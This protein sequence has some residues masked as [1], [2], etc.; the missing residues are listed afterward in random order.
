MGELQVFARF[1]EGTLVA[2]SCPAA[3][4]VAD[5]IEEVRQAGG[6][7]MAPR[8]RFLEVILE[9]SM[10]VADTGVTSEAVVE[11]VPTGCSRVSIA[12]GSG[13]SLALYQDGAKMLA[14]GGVGATAQRCNIP[15]LEEF[16]SGL[17]DLKVAQ[18]TSG[19][20]CAFALMEDQTV[21]AWGNNDYGQRNVPD[22]GGLKVVEIAAGGY[23]VIA[24]MEDLTVRAWGDNSLGQCRIPDFGGLNVIKI[25]GGAVHSMAL[26]EDHTVRAWG[27]ND[28]GQCTV[29]DLGDEKVLQIAAGG[30]HSMVLTENHVVRAWGYNDFGQ[31]NLTKFEG[32]KIEHIAAGGHHSIVLTDDNQV[33]ATG[34]VGGRK[35]ESPCTVPDFKGAKVVQI[36]GGGDHSM[37]MMDDN[38]VWAW[39][40]NRYGQCTV[41]DVLQPPS[42]RKKP[43]RTGCCA[44]Q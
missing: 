2:V 14:W 32:L 15:D 17:N 26:L 21:R 39:G 44:S 3:A 36:A 22:F 23:H 24:L 10:P 33:L 12:A 8:L 18:I 4:T 16:G 34:A 20:Y 30:V 42:L 5:L 11:V 25:A 7:R 35:E 29:P 9:S 41:P 38:T 37:A 31:C 43:K 6:L 40:N 19:A 1:P 13:H 28:K 27:Y